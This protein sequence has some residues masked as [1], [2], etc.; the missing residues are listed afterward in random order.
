MRVDA[1][2]LALCLGLMA[3]GCGGSNVPP[4]LALEIQSDALTRTVVVAHEAQ[5]FPEGKGALWCATSRLAW[6]AVPRRE[7]GAPLA[8]SPPA[9]QAA[10]LL[11]DGEPYPIEALDPASIFVH[12]GFTGP[13][14][15]G[16]DALEAIRSGMRTDFEREP[17]LTELDA[18]LPWGAVGYAF[19]RK[20]LPFAHRFERSRRGL[21][22]EGSERRIES[23]HLPEEAPSG[24]L[25][26]VREQVS[27][28]FARWPAEGEEGRFEGAVSIP[29]R[30]GRDRLVLALLPRGNSLLSTWTACMDSCAGEEPRPLPADADFAVPMAHFELSH[31]FDEFIGGE[32]DFGDRGAAVLAEYRQDVAFQLTE[33]GV[34]LEA[35]AEKRFKAS[36]AAVGPDRPPRFVFDRPFL[37]GLV[38]EGSGTPYLLWWVENDELLVPFGP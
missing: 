28:L 22:F 24:E 25:E 36:M 37:L 23:F 26:R 16:A 30:D 35:E 8:L 20:S 31:G 15:R 38:Q 13:A 10:V 11:M 19:L 5:P 9:D 7:P 6:D 2:A 1:P 18:G 3:A 21:V 12:G 29:S 14:H 32:A 17:R 33:R 4:P 34:E 27:V